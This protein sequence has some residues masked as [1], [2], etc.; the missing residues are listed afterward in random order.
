MIL[1]K[2]LAVYIIQKH[3]LK[4]NKINIVKSL[5]YII[6][7]EHCENIIYFIAMFTEEFIAWNKI[8]LVEFIL[9][10]KPC[11]NKETPKNQETIMYNIIFNQSLDLIF[12][13]LN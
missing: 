2:I 4:I 10:Y 12:R 5:S 9:N 11:L 8:L 6:G 7:I 3:R 13:P 1:I